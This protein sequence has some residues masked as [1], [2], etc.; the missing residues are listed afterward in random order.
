M[1]TDPSMAIMFLVFLALFVLLGT[2]PVLRHLIAGIGGLMRKIGRMQHASAESALLRKPDESHRS[3]LHLNDYEVLVF[4]TLAM[5]G[6]KGLSLR[7][8]DSR[9]H[10]KPENLN[11]SL[12][13]LYERGL[14]RGEPLFLFW[15]RFYLSE[16]GR[17]YAVAQDMIPQIHN[18]NELRARL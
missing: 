9:L 3:S 4:R 5:A 12:E 7:D 8:L 13:S 6:K 15:V 1:P 18:G 2:S 11:R 16:R 14:I 10:F 17:N